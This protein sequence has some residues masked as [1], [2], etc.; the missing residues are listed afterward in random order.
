MFRGNGAEMEEA[1]E[2]LGS[3]CAW[4]GAPVAK[5]HPTQM[6]AGKYILDRLIAWLGISKKC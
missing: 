6:M 3:G 2:L 1:S 4:R 5:R